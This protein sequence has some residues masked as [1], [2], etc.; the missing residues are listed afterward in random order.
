MNIT[1]IIR[2]VAV[3]CAVL[4]AGTLS[5]VVGHAAE[6]AHAATSTSQVRKAKAV[7]QYR[8]DLTPSVA[9]TLA[10]KAERKQA[11]RAYLH[12]FGSWENGCKA[13]LRHAYQGRTGKGGMK[14]VQPYLPVY[15]QT[16]PGRDIYLGE[17]A[18]G[19]CN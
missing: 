1:T 14:H 2:P 4:V 15:R 10:G 3:G 7:S 17:Y 8:A 11:E 5:A 9:W 19:V 16:V 13:D 6:P 12:E 18:E